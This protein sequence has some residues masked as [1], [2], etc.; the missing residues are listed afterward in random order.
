[1]HILIT[2]WSGIN[3]FEKFVLNLLLISVFSVGFGNTAGFCILALYLLTLL[4]SDLLIVVL[5]ISLDFICKQLG[6]L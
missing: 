3:N 1:M 6:H 5:Q 4:N 2:G